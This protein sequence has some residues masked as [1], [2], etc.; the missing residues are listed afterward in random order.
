V[1]QL[2]L[3]FGGRLVGLTISIIG[4]RKMLS[5]APLLVEARGA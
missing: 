2:Q 1:E 5:S 3:A 4:S